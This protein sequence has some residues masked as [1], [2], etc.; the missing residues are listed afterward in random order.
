[1]V[2]TEHKNKKTANETEEKGQRN[3]EDNISNDN[4]PHQKYIFGYLISLE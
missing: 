3:R 4:T 2:P 1:M